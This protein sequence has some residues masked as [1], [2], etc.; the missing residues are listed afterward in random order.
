[1]SDTTDELPATF[2]LELAKPISFDGREFATLVLREP[3]VKEVLQADEQL[4]HGV[5]PASLRNRE[6]HLVSKVAGVPLP[7]VEQ[8]NISALNAAMAY[9]NPFLNSGQ[10]TGGS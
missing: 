7:V 1:M 5:T 6:I 10:V 8:I 3:R 4:R 9:L 2:S